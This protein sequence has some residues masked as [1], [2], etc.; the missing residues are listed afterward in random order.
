V[1]TATITPG[2]VGLVTVDV[3]AN[4]A[5]DGAANGNMAAPTLRVEDVRC[6][7]GDDKVY[8]C[9]NGQ[10]I[11]VAL[12]SVKAHLL[13]GDN[14]GSCP[15]PPKGNNEF[16][17]RNLDL[18]VYPNPARE[19]A[20]IEFTMLDAGNFTLALYDLRGTLVKKIADGSAEADEFFS[21][22]LNVTPYPVGVYV[23]RLTT[24]QRVAT[25][26]LVIHK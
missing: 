22:Q 14:I 7:Y 2:A 19:K 16:N 13:H 10:M 20:T 1:Y 23:V 21:Y 6:G 26:R 9:H 12:S 17:V 18:T 4:V 25:K 8:M 3:A 11:C 15:N 24:T 5:Q